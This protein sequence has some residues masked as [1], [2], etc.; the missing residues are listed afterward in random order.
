MNLARPEIDNDGSVDIDEAKKVPCHT[1]RHQARN[2]R[3]QLG[4]R[5]T[6]SRSRRPIRSSNGLAFLEISQYRET[7][8]SP[9]EMFEGMSTED[10][11][12]INYMIREL[13]QFSDRVQQHDHE[14]IESPRISSR[15]QQ[16]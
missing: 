15:E 9:E 11:A 6:A 16:E 14:P 7:G 2:N 13:K 8:E 12:A 3:F 5:T 10:E 4:P 1:V